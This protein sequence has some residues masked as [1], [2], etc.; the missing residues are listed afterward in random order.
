M[1]DLVPQ[2]FNRDQDIFVNDRETGATERVSV[3]ALAGDPR[4][5]YAPNCQR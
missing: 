2:D 3:D 1:A 4:S 5:R